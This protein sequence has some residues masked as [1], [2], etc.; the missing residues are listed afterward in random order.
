[1]R[2]STTFPSNSAD[3]SASTSLANTHGCPMSTLPLAL[4]LSFKVDC[5]EDMVP[6]LASPGAWEGGKPS[7]TLNM[8]KDIVQTLI[9]PDLLDSAA[10]CWG[11]AGSDLRFLRAVENFV[12]AF[13]R[14]SLPLILR[15]TH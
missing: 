13:E 10:R 6:S 11:V 1:S 2:H 15:L 12:Y 4:G 7:P 9:T 5:G 3:N 8:H 14:A